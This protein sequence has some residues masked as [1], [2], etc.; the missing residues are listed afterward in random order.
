ME[1]FLIV[2]ILLLQVGTLVLLAAVANVL[3]ALVDRA[4]KLKRQPPREPGLVDLPQ[5]PNYAQVG[6]PPPSEGLVL[7]KD[8]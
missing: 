1:T 6:P 2:L 5:V 7:V 8:Q 4:N 3:F